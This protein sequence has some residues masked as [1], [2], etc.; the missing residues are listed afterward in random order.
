M[1]F[2]N[3]YNRFPRQYEKPSGISKVEVAGYIPAKTKIESLIQAGAR[4]IQSRKEQY[5][6]PPGT[7]VTGDEPIDPTRHLKLDRVEIDAMRNALEDRLEEQIR[8]KKAR[9]IEK[10]KQDSLKDSLKKVP[11]KIIDK[12]DKVE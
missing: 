12:N 5:D 6:Y 8:L 2:Q 1:L 4:L 3:K 7:N 10:D 9:E 11:E